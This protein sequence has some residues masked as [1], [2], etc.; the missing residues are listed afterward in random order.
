MVLNLDCSGRGSASITLVSFLVCYYRTTEY[1]QDIFSVD[2]NSLCL[3][4]F[5]ILAGT[6]PS[7][8]PDQDVVMFLV[9]PVERCGIFAA[10]ASG[11]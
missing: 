6:I 5:N 4:R 11:F 9:G 8:H 10:L 3:D 7:S 1:R 2:F